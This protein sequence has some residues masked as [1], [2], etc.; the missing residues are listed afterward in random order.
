MAQSKFKKI[1]D[2]INAFIYKDSTTDKFVLDLSGDEAGDRGTFKKV[3]DALN[4]IAEVDSPPSLDIRVGTPTEDTQLANKK[5]VDDNAGGGGGGGSQIRTFSVIVP[6]G[7]TFAVDMPIHL[8]VGAAI[9]KS[10]PDPDTWIAPRDGSIKNLNVV[11]NG[12]NGHDGVTTFTI[13]VESNPSAVTVTGPAGGT[14]LVTSPGAAVAT[15]S[16][17]EEV[18]CVVDSTASSTGSTVYQVSY[19]LV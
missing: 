15:F 8:L 4:N 11:A 18:A 13:E 7:E 6:D 1:L 2:W 17:G 19:E 10:V 14:A 9:P 5:Y 16:A 12:A 3:L